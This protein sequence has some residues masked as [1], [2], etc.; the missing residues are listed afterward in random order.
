MRVRFVRPGVALAI[1]REARSFD[2][3]AQATAGA[4]P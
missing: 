3:S 4:A 2:A 1:A